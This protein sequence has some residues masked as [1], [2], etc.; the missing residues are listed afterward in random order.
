MLLSH[1]K[2]AGLRCHHGVA[3]K[4]VALSSA[5]LVAPAAQQLSKPQHR[6]SLRC[7]ALGEDNTSTAAASAAN[8]AEKLQELASAVTNGTS[9]SSG[10]SN[11]PTATVA[12]PAASGAEPSNKDDNDASKHLNWQPEGS[13]LAPLQFAPLSNSEKAWTNFKLLFALPWRRFKKDA[14]LAFKLEGEISDQLQG[15]FSPGFSMP[16]IC[17]SLEK[18]AVDPRIKGIVVE[19]N[20]LAIGWSKVQELRRYIQLFRD[21]G[22]FTIAYMKIAGEKEYYL[23]TAFEEVYVAPSAS[24]RLAGFSVAG[25]FLRGVLEKVGVE[26]QVQRIGEYKSAGDQLLRKDMSPAQR[27]QLTELLDDI[28]EHFLDT[29]AA[30]RGKTREVRLTGI[31]APVLREHVMQMAGLLN[32]QDSSANNPA[33]AVGSLFTCIGSSCISVVSG[34]CVV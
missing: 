1:T 25:T 21:S 27:E 9:A 6:I 18:A 16:Q 31:S 34:H 28:Y 5:R 13:T 7:S 17:D 32:M 2:G 29:V 8:Q 11:T 24:V 15:R 4:P 23:S 14:V 30:A 22:K 26:P 20:P 3:A 10:P 33:E 19:I 12:K